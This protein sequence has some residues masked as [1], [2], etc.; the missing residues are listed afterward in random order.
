MVQI[1]P[2]EW[3]GNI[4]HDRKQKIEQ[5]TIKNELA[6]KFL[7]SVGEYLFINVDAVL[8]GGV[9]N[10]NRGTKTDGRC[11]LLLSWE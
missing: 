11:T 7:I 6:V 3:F 9:K 1:L 5:F 10:L 4:Q 2:G 8:R